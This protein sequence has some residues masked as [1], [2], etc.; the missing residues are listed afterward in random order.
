VFSLLAHLSVVG[1]R[2]GD[3]VTR[4]EIIGQVGATGRV[5]GPHLHWA[6]RMNGARVDPVVVLAV[7]GQ[8]RS[9]ARKRATR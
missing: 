3:M 1:V 5:T 2:E 4:G 9:A 7:V 6:V 8:E